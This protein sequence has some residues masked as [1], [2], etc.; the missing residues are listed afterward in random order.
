ET[1]ERLG[2]MPPEDINASV[3]WDDSG[4][5]LY[6]FPKQ[7]NWFTLDIYT[8]KKF[9]ENAAL[10]YT[11]EE[12]DP[13]EDMEFAAQT[14]GANTQWTRFALPNGRIISPE[15]RFTPEIDVLFNGNISDMD[16]LITAGRTL[17]HAVLDAVKER[18]G[19]RLAASYT[20][21]QIRQLQDLHGN[22]ETAVDQ[23]FMEQVTSG[24]TSDPE[25]YPFQPTY[26]RLSQMEATIANMQR[27]EKIMHIGTGWPGTA[28][29]L[30][31]QF[32]ISVTCVEKDREV[33]E[34]SAAALE[35]LG[36]LGTNKL[37]VV[38]ADG[39]TI[40]PEQ[41]GAV[42]IS[43]MVPN[44][45]KSKIIENMKRLA[46]GNQTDPLL[47]LRTPTDRA[48][49]LFYQ[50]LTGEISSNK[51]IVP[52]A[53]TSSLLVCSDPLRSIAYRVREMAAIRR[54]EDYIL[55]SSRS[56]LQVA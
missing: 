54:G 4:A 34:K 13:R 43:A 49:S 15:S 36:L 5:Q 12:L 2:N 37:R 47:I 32:G 52:L 25:D 9:D 42:I 29:G 3:M 33:A 21:E 55:N 26:D 24:K 48:R 35:K 39:S 50:E 51:A 11:Y 31:R 7:E 19:K 16:R 30:Y 28:I 20:E 38:C 23:R 14:H 27:G 41:Y 56:Q 44:S 6:V 53:D 17:E 22:F 10:V 8:C 18:S 46:T 45:D 40:N 1:F